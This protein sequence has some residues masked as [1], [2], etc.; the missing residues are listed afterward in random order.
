MIETETK[1]NEKN[2]A[3]QE[4]LQAEAS[5]HS[6]E[7]SQ[8]GS[9]ETNYK[10]QYFYNGI[11]STREIIISFLSHRKCS[12]IT[13]IKVSEK[14]V[15]YHTIL[16]NQRKWYGACLD[17]GAQTTVIGLQQ[18]KA[19]C[20]FMNITYNLR[21]NKNKYKFGDDKQNSLGALSIKIP[22][23]D[24]MVIHESVDVVR[25]NVPLLIG[26]DFLDKYE[27]YVNNV[28]NILCC[29]ALDI[30]VP[31]KRK[32]GHVYLIWKKCDEILYTRPELLKLLKKFSH[33]ASDK[34]FNLLKLAR[35][36][37]TNAETK[38][39][40]DEIQ[41]MC[42][43]FQ[44]IS[45][46]PIRFKV[47]LPSIEYLKFGDK[48]SLDLML[49]N[50][51]A[52]L[53]VVDTATRFSAATFLDSNGESYGQS[54]EGLWLAFVQTWCTVYPGYPN[55]LR[56]DQGSVFTSIRWKQLTDL[57]GIE[58]RI[59]GVQAHSSLEI[60]ERLH[61][62]LRRIYQ[63]IRQ[64]Y[65]NVVP[66]LVLKV[67]VKA[68]NDT[69]GENGLVPTR[70]VFGVIPRVPI[71][72]TELPTQIERME[73]LPAA[74]AEMISIVAERKIMTALTRDIPPAADRV[75][76]TGE[77][78]LVY[79]E[80]EKKRIGA[81]IFIDVKGRMITVQSIDKIKRKRFNAFQIKLYYRTINYSINK[82]KTNVIS[83]PPFQVYLTEVIEPRDPRAWKFNNAKLKELDGLIKNKT[84]KIVCRNEVPSNAN[85]LNGRFVLAI[86]DEGKNKEVWKARYVVEGHRDSMR[87]S[88]VHNT[89]VA[90]QQSTKLVVGIAAIFGFNLFSS[91]ITQAYLQNS[92]KLMR[93][94]YL[95]PPKKLNLD[96]GQLLKLLKPL[97][98]LSESGDYWGRT[99]RKHLE[100]DIGMRSCLSDAALFF[101]S[102]GNKLAGICST[103]VDDTLHAGNEKY[104][105]CSK[106]TEKK[107][108][109]KRR[110]WDKLQFASV[111]IE[112]TIEGFQVHQFIYVNKLKEL[113]DN[114]S[115]CDF[116][117][118]RAKLAWATNKRPDI[119]CA[120]AKLTQNTEESYQNSETLQKKEIN[121]VVR[122]LKE[123]STVTLKFPKLNKS[124][125]SL[126]VNSDASF[127]SNQDLSSQLVYFIFLKDD[128]SRCQPL[129]WTS[130]T[131][132]RV[133][134]SVFGCE[135]MAF[136]DAL[137]WLMLQSMIYK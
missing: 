99:L 36:W 30:Q 94:V 43:T 9:D 116:R 86:K 19:Y 48:L 54:V 11:E 25:A 70:L 55:R 32:H 31:L 119:C 77:E 120:V 27:L 56:T 123:N 65:P 75:Y 28:K 124:S 63:K 79:S 60:G 96:P 59:F 7:S 44:R 24:K 26:L 17:T 3:Y 1:P 137:I 89:T 52:V 88:L 97:Y 100:S 42:N 50:E 58:L 21:K 16:S 69:I 87:Q 102:F 93:D 2:A 113:P 85:I 101:K 110:D 98:A 51:R 129:F 121:K 106:F 95:N 14:S 41:N 29:S 15:F 114:A 49:L 6:H 107:F 117:S 12:A 53:H 5:D 37:E 8:S 4:R 82:F 78:I 61:E 115:H 108:Q 40:L 128:H 118:L 67:A 23:L 33:L 45:H 72:S 64:D 20:K 71:I 111:Q 133:N 62:P 81:F 57:N 91:D 76:K 46:A 35:P 73:I 18:A 136:A 13:L 131:A 66:G 104:C 39:I 126:H 105:E 68:M 80:N 130:Y 125:L 84:W 127:A 134:R 103:Y 83:P 47:S 22:I 92:E 34:L 38:R 122:H 112:K 10:E 74:Q 90:R 132:K 109:C 135:V